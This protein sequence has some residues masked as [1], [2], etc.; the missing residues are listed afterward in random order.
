METTS[1]R[2]SLPQSP[3]KSQTVH[4]LYG[5]IATDKNAFD[6]MPSEEIVQAAFGITSATPS[7]VDVTEALI[8]NLSA[9]DQMKLRSKINEPLVVGDLW[10]FTTPKMF[11]ITLSKIPTGVNTHE[12]SLTLISKYENSETGL[13]IWSRNLALIGSNGVRFQSPRLR[14]VE[15]NASSVEMLQKLHD[16]AVAKLEQKVESQEQPAPEP[17]TPEPESNQLPP[18]PEEI[19]IPQDTA[20]PSGKEMLDDLL[21]KKNATTP[22]EPPASTETQRR[23]AIYKD[24]LVEFS[25]NP[26]DKDEVV[27]RGKVDGTGVDLMLFTDADYRKVYKTGKYRANCDVYESDF[28]NYESLYWLME[29]FDIIE[30]PEEPVAQPTQPAKEEEAQPM[31]ESAP[32]HVPITVADAYADI[33]S[34]LIEMIQLY[35]AEHPG[36]SDQQLT[37]H[38]R[39]CTEI[40][41]IG[42]TNVD[43]V[44]KVDQCVKEEK[45]EVPTIDLHN[46]E[47]QNA[48]LR[49]MFGVADPAITHLQ[50]FLRN[51]LTEE[52]NAGFLTTGTFPTETTIIYT[53][54]PY[55]VT[56]VIVKMK[57]G[58]FYRIFGAKTNLG[59]PD[60]GYIATKDMP[61]RWVKLGRDIQ[62][63]SYRGEQ[64]RR[65]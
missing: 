17:T 12:L 52:N 32:T 23:I 6:S 48:L 15:F 61:G 25:L 29:K 27:V 46:V 37:E 36:A 3:I 8:S 58:R 59:L 11:M 50:K 65:Y 54:K 42:V 24:E 22:E 31:N 34:N 13:E 41:E 62:D 19:P 2:E 20:E 14:R 40:D 44:W 16:E 38:V 53:Q 39:A 28:K 51:H 47:N 10:Q 55:D 43:G 18:P 4:F 63:V 5:K 30:E 9:E 7:S 57:D 1:L 56:I 21:E 26:N 60:P 35:V 64:R 45:E 49:G 33:A